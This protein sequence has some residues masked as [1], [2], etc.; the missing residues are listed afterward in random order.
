MTP[1][2]VPDTA[3]GTLV[4]LVNNETGNTIDRGADENEGDGL[5]ASFF[6]CPP[7][8]VIIETTEFACWVDGI[9]DDTGSMNFSTGVYTF[10][11]APALLAVITWRFDYVYWD[12]SL[13]EAAVQAGIDNIFPYFYH[14]TTEVMGTGVE[15]TFITPGA[16]VVTMVA[17]TGTS[18]TRIPRSKYTTYKSGDDLVLRWYG[19]APSGTLRANIICRPAIVNDMLNVTSRATAPIVSYATYYLLTQKPAERMRADTAVATVGQGNLSPRQINDA[20]NSFFLRYQAQ[21]QQSK[22]LP[23]SMS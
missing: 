3:M 16:E 9:L 22:Q 23:W 6:I 8:R 10:P 15:H 18:V 20:S 2:Y 14:P 5:S 11:T 12:D 7:M 19:S 4:A 1:I 17:T 21:C 13:V